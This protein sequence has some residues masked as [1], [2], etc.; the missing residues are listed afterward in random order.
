MWY[1]IIPS[2]TVFTAHSA[3]KIQQNAIYWQNI[4]TLTHKGQCTEGRNAVTNCRSLHSSPSSLFPMIDSDFQR[5][6]IISRQENL[7]T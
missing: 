1:I 5:V 4:N 6:G 7:S 3:T 2:K